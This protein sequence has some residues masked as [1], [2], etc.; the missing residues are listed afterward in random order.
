MSR[1][2]RLSDCLY[3]GLLRLYPRA[4]RDE[5]AE[6]MQA[7]FAEQADEAA[8]RDSWSLVR[9][10]L[11]EAGDLFRT[12]LLEHWA[13][14]GRRKQGARMGIAIESWKRLGAEPDEPDKPASRVASVAAMLPFLIYPIMTGTVFGLGWIKQL[15]NLSESDWIIVVSYLLWLLLAGFALALGVGW[16][17]GFPRWAFPYWGLGLLLSLYMQ[18]AATPG[19]VLFGYTFGPRELWGWRAWV[20]VLLAICGGLVWT[21]SLKPLRELASGVWNDWT[22]LSF[23]LYG[24]LPQ[25]LPIFLDEIR[26]VQPFLIAF[27]LV[28]AVGALA[29][30]R[31]TDTTRRVASLLIGLTTAWAG[32]TIYKAF[33]WNVLG[34]MGPAWVTPWTQTVGQMSWTWAI[35]T[36]ILCVPVLLGI[37]RHAVNSL[38]PA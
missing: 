4:F 38:H 13:V 26:G 21:R 8:A 19:L 34:E 36:I 32:A 14:I 7:V 28:L 22:R 11:R 15:A 1:F 27:D 23:A 2:L 29:Y 25:V 18:E 35:I 10:C 24:W 16:V 6:E 31:S 3:A 37:I 20:P 17:K 12:A 9:L 30:M 33:Y 5:F